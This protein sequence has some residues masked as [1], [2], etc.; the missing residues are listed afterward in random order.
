MSSGMGMGMGAPALSVDPAIAARQ[1]AGLDQLGV[2][3]TERTR[4]EMEIIQRE[5]EANLIA[6]GVAQEEAR[7]QA[8]ATFKQATDSAN[9]INQD[10]V[11]ARED[12]E[13]DNLPDTPGNEYI[14]QRTTIE[15][16]REDYLSGIFDQR[17]QLENTLATAQDAIAKYQELGASGALPMETVRESIG[18]V[19]RVIDST[20]VALESVGESIREAG[21]EFDKALENIDREFQLAQEAREFAFRERA[22]GLESEFTREVTGRSLNRQGAGADRIR[23]DRDVQAAEIELNFDQ[24]IRALDDLV[25]AGELSEDQAQDLRE[26]ME[27]LANVRLENLTEETERLVQELYRI[28]SDRLFELEGSILDAQTETANIYGIGSAGQVEGAAESRAIAM[29]ERTSRLD[30]EAFQKMATDAGVASEEISRVTA[31]MERLNGLTLENI[32]VQFDQWTPAI[33]TVKSSTDSLFSSLFDRTKTLGESFRGF[34][35]NVIDGFGQLAAKSLSDGIFGSLMRTDGGAGRERGGGSQKGADGFFNS[36]LGGI[37]NVF[38]F[39]DG[40]VVPMAG[41]NFDSMRGGRDAIAAALQREGP[42]SVLAALTPGEMVLTRP[43][44]ASYLEYKR[45]FNF[46]EGGV[47]PGANTS[48]SAS[49]IQFAVNIGGINVD[50]KGGAGIDPTGIAIMLQ[51]SVPGLVRQEIARQQGLGG[52]LNREN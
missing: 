51:Q 23:S 9:Q 44:T 45:V 52:S 22:E 21:T 36:I 49:P 32:R 2:Q 33:N 19:Q 29:Q 17:N 7:R 34:F 14:R 10:A 25:R 38:N 3:V 27:S 15:R 28:P 50:A 35:E 1:Q 8:E 13:L 43:E 18:G 47:V 39:A 30:I 31:E 26:V 11:R 16:E 20:Q 41:R 42:D 5:Y 4:L 12:L 37:A 40:G 48:V 46:A 6:A 24:E